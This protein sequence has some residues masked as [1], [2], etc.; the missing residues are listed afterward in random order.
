MA[1]LNALGATANAAP[2]ATKDAS[3]NATGT[4]PGSVNKLETFGSIWTGKFDV[5]RYRGNNLT[6]IL[7]DQ[8][9]DVLDLFASWSNARLVNRMPLPFWQW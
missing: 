4:K 5:Y 9:E 1:T 3:R 6:H 2:N 7:S 8:I